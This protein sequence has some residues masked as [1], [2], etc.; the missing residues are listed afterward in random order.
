LHPLLLAESSARV[1]ESSRSPEA[2]LR[3]PAWVAIREQAANCLR[4]LNF[5]LS[6]W[7]AVQ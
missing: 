5:D 4:A 2:L 3:H 6:A 7:E 1:V